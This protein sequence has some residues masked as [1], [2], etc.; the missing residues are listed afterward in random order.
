[1]IDESDQGGSASSNSDQEMITISREKLEELI[2]R[3]IEEQL[4]NLNEEKKEISRR[5]TL[6]VI[7]AGFAGVGLLNR[8]PSKYGD[9]SGLRSAIDHGGVQDFAVSAVKAKSIEATEELA[10]PEYDDTSNAPAGSG[11]TIYVTGN[12]PNS[13]GLYTYDGSTYT[14]RFTRTIYVQNSEPTDPSENDIWIDTS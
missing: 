6:G 11:K 10:L 2:D 14:K 1:M 5:K 9:P 7:G 12:G 13:E 4:S 8:N 3:R